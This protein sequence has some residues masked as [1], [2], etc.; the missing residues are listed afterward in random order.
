MFSN[1]ILGDILKQLPRDVVSDK[2]RDHGSDRW[3]KSFKRWDQLVALLTAQLSGASSLREL[4]AVFNAQSRHHYHLNAHPVRR[5][6]LSEPPGAGSPLCSA[7][8]P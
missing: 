7:I 4:E 3:S 6:T 8:S 5:S 2:V 1:S